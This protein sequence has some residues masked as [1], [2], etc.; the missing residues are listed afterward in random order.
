[1]ASDSPADM[2][3]SVVESPKERSVRQ[4]PTSAEARGLKSKASAAKAGKDERTRPPMYSHTYV[5]HSALRASPLSKESPEQDYRGFYNLSLLLLAVSN[6]RLMVENYMKYGFLLSSPFES[7]RTS[8]LILALASFIFQGGC[9]LA[10][11]MTESWAT[12]DIRT[13][14]PTRKRVRLFYLVNIGLGIF[15]PT[16]LSWVI[17]NPAISAAPLFSAT[18][19]MLKLVSY[20]LVCADMRREVAWKIVP[21]RAEEPTAQDAKIERDLKFDVEQYPYPRNIT[22]GNLMY[23]VFS[24]TL[25]YQPVYPRTQRFRKSFF[26]KRL[27]EMTTCAA[28][29]YLLGA[30]YA[31][32]TLRNSL[33]AID[34][35][36]F[37]HLVE[38]VLKLSI[39]SV[40][41]WLLMFYVFFHCALNMLAE[42][43]RFGDRRFYL[44]WWNAKDI[45]EYWRLW[46]TPVHNWG[47]RH[48]YMPLIIKYKFSPTSASIFVFT[49]SAVLHELLIGVPTGCLNGWAFMGMMLQL[50]LILQTRALE[51]LRRKNEKLFDT[52]GN[53]MFWISFTIVGQPTCVLVYY[54]NWY[55]RNYL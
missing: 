24:P 1:M 52:I 50:P 22:L 29:M 7:V 19:L 27:L 54:S 51:P 37:V 5:I 38:R 30:Q 16:V 10:A 35:L 23:F 13:D 46:N 44:T 43:M 48:V 40:V 9:I 17:W 36:N 31:A 3:A 20:G 25:C 6:I 41:I 2:I 53:Y 11:Y 28:A 12:R 15:V 14:R 34:Q 42:V 18:I 45:A 39:V 33:K 26:L 32:P 21:H 8:D 4:R 55:K 47:K 49:I